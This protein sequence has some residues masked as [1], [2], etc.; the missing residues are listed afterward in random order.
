MPF[1]RVFIRIRSYFFPSA[2]DVAGPHYHNRR[3][4]RDFYDVGNR[5]R[6]DG[7]RSALFTTTGYSLGPVGRPTARWHT[8]EAR[9]QEYRL[10]LSFAGRRRASR[11]LPLV[12]AARPRF[13]IAY[14]YLSLRTYLSACLPTRRETGDFLFFYL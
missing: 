14:A 12:R 2:V 1:R 9:F 6:R 7:R 3:R 11:S 5:V 4:R 13:V 10:A 8:A